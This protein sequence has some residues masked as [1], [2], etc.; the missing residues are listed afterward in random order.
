VATGKVE[1]GAIA[2]GTRVEVLGL[3]SVLETVATSVEQFHRPLERAVAGQN[4][5]LL[6][7]GVKSDQVERGQVIAAPRSLRPRT[8]FR[9][10]LYVLGKE[11]GGRHTPFFSGYRPQFFF[12]TTSV[13]GELILP[14]EVE[15][16]M[17]GDNTQVEVRL[18]TPIAL[19]SGSH[20]AVR[21][22]GK[23]VG[24]G[25]VTEVIE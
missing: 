10:E 19:E 24:S 17:P 25:V 1:Q 11:E 7:R 12:R 18:D 16:V 20:F 15:M 13:T 14:E 21:E 8:K 23:T 22:G 2:P 4:V 6:L 5:G 9:G 3:G